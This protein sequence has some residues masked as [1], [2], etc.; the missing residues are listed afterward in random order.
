[1]NSQDHRH[2]HHHSHHRDHPPGNHQHD[3]DWNSLYTGDASD[4]EAPD[5]RLLP[6]LD[7]IPPGRALD[8]GCGAGGLVLELARR[9]WQV[10]G[11][12]ISKKAI[13]AA[14][15][16]LQRADLDARFQ[17]GDAASWQPAT[18]YDLVTSTFALPVALDR[19]ARVLDTIRSAVAPG[20]LVLV[21]EFDTGMARYP[22]CRDMN[23]LTVSDLRAAFPGFDVLRAE[24]EPTP[25]HEHAG[26]AHADEQWTSVLFHG[27]RPLT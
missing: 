1:M 21:Q 12:D 3:F 14:R 25:V 27:R 5:P 6:L 22:F 23:L 17:V 4:Y 2:D 8:V 20:G 7:S 13:A 16:V 18:Q 19:R 10:T 11:L 9:G 24:V 26:S 15:A